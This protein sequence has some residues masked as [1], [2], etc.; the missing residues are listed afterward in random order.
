MI[1]FLSS[2]T[3]MTYNTVGKP[4]LFQIDPQIVHESALKLGRWSGRQTWLK[5][6]TRS[7]FAYKHPSLEQNLLGMSLVTPIGLAAGY[8]YELALPEFSGSLGLG[9]QSVGSIT[10][11]AYSGNQPP[12]YGRLPKSKSLWINKGFKNPGVHEAKK[13]LEQQNFSVP[14]GMSIGAT[15][16]AYESTAE[17]I[18]EYVQAFQI[19]Q[20]I[21]NL[22]YFELNI[23]CPNLHTKI[24]WSEPKLLERLLSAVD[25]CAIKQPIFIKMPIDVSESTLKKMLQVIR[26]HKIAGIILGNLTKKRTNSRIWRS[27]LVNIPDHGGFSGLPT[28]AQGEK[29]IR[30]AYREVGGELIIIGCGGIFSGQDAYRKLRAGASAL[31]MI[32]GL[33]FQGPQIVG[34]IHSELAELL[35]KDGYTHISQVVG[36]DAMQ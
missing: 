21:P 11:G 5:F 25:T 3:G 35:V 16:R 23:S 33:I 4:L 26:K 20:T 6:L 7:L 1:R 22:S 8:D 29:L 10:L 15:N 12:M 13:R 19:A 24:D 34:Q 2:L 14:V 36:L 18:Q 9:W 30:C 17:L 31:Q 28:Q 32:T 27:E